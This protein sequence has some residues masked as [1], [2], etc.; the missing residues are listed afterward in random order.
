M[1]KVFHRLCFC[2][3]LQCRHPLLPPQL[4]QN[5]LQHQRLL[6]KKNRQKIFKTEIHPFLQFGLS[7]KTVSKTVKILKTV[8]ITVYT[9]QLVFLTLI[10][11]GF[12]SSCSNISRQIMPMRD[13]MSNPQ[14]YEDLLWPWLVKIQMKRLLKGKSN[15]F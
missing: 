13:K 2:Q 7:Q 10:W 6:K 11:P 15:I 1:R 3:S 14:R 5:R 9:L 4:I 12:N 8:K